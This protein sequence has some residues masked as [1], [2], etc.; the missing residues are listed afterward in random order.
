MREIRSDCWA[1]SHQLEMAARQTMVRITRAL[2]DI[3]RRGEERS[4]ICFY[5]RNF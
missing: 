3:E 5:S 2:L 4:E 1:L